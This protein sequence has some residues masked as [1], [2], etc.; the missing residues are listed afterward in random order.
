MTKQ[1]AVLAVVLAVRLLVPLGIPRFPLPSILAALVMDA[2]DQTIFQAVGAG[3]DI[4]GYQSYDKALDVYY[5]TIAYASVL[6]NWLDPVALSVGRFLF[7]WRLTGV[8]AFELTGAR[9]LLIVF[10]NTFEYFFIFY[11]SVRLF[12]DPRRLSRLQ[13]LGAAAAIWVVI[14]LPQEYWI[15]IA[16]L[17]LT[18]LL[19]EHAWLLPTL[20]AALALLAAVAVRLSRRLPPA[21]RRPS[22]D[23]DAHAVRPRG[24]AV[25]PRTDVRAILSMAV[26]EKVVLISMVAIIFSQVLPGVDATER[27]IAAAVAFVVVA[28]SVVSLWR[29]RRGTRWASTLIQFVSMLALNVTLIVV[30]SMLTPGDSEAFNP[31]GTLFYLFLISLIITMYDRYRTIGNAARR[32]P[33]SPVPAS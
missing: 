27:E 12:W 26:L 7:Y 31:A 22:F 23:A 8:V 17:D 32:E 11:E 9:A 19:S 3:S 21:D 33:V 30:E 4:A 13:V 28:N 29:V 10:P 15:H 16:Q 20:I 6:R 18:D 25:L 24:A 1:D 2:A 5:L 14:K